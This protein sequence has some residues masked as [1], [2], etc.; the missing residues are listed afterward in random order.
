M[1]RSHQNLFKST[2]VSWPRL[3]RGALVAWRKS[4]A[5]GG[6][7]SHRTH[8][9]G[10]GCHTR[11]LA[12]SFLETCCGFPL[13]GAAQQPTKGVKSCICKYLR[14]IAKALATRKGSKR[15]VSARQCVRRPRKR[16][17]CT[18]RHVPGC[19]WLPNLPE[20]VQNDLLHKKPGQG[21]GNA[22]SGV[23]SFRFDAFRAVSGHRRHQKASKTTFCTK[24]W[25]GSCSLRSPK[26]SF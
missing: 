21:L 16:S 14:V 4:H 25:L 10:S 24:S 3:G 1:G 8:W 23:Q 22:A 15:M 18:K 19:S 12:Q 2:S 9:R 20:S 7:N 5:N 17:K 26:L 11:A 13:F 6:P